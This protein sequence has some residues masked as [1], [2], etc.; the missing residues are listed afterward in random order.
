[1]ETKN[2]TLPKDFKENVTLLYLDPYNNTFGEHDW[3]VIA[4]MAIFTICC[5]ISLGLMIG[6]VLFERFGPNS[7]HRV[8]I[9]MVRNISKVLHD[10]FSSTGVPS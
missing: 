6:I 4:T 8:F 9:D 5:I 7:G 3:L 10:V 1:M 2:I